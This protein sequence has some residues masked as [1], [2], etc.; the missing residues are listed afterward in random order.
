MKGRRVGGDGEWK[1]E[2]NRQ[3]QRLSMQLHQHFTKKGAAN[4]TSKPW[5]KRSKQQAIHSD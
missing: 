2:M 1:G 4:K 3:K 5:C